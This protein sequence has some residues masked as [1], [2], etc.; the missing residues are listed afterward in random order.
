MQEEEEEEDDGTDKTGTAQQLRFASWRRLMFL[1]PTPSV[2]LPKLA[3]VLRK[4]VALGANAAVNASADLTR[5]PEKLSQKTTL[6]ARIAEL[7]LVSK[8]RARSLLGRSHANC[9]DFETQREVERK[10]TLERYAQVLSV[11]CKNWFS[12]DARPHTRL[13]DKR[14]L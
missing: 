14:Q 4:P 2:S 6:R 7:L 3:N 13:P 8:L 9:V 11:T 5:S 12:E 1:T 10:E